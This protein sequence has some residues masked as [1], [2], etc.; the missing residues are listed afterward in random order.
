M[1]WLL[2]WNP[3]PEIDQSSEPSCRWRREEKA[4]PI[5]VVGRSAVDRVLGFGI[6]IDTV[7]GVQ[8]ADKGS[9]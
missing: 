7:L 3:A 2:E 4:N 9:V 1:L 8:H 5:S 6:V